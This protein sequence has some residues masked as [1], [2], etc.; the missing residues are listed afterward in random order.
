VHLRNY[1]VSGEINNSQ[2]WANRNI[3]TDFQIDSYVSVKDF[4]ALKPPEH[5]PGVVEEAFSEGAAC[6]S[7]GANNAAAAMFRL[8][9][10]L[11]TKGFLPP[12][13]TESGPTRQQR[14]VL[15]SRLDWLFQQKLLAAD[16]KELATSVREDG[17]DG[18]HDGNL[19]QG[20]AEDLADFSVALLTRIYTEPARIEVAKQRRQAR[21]SV[22]D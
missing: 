21:R 3:N 4:A 2:Y 16:L 17:N 14:R 18:V 22:Q 11:A 13:D 9:I 7:I 12:E 10:D 6:L 5:L 1:N 20:E 15:A 19:A 8:T